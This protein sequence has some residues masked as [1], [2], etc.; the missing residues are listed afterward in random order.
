[1]NKLLSFYN[2]YEFPI[3]VFITTISA[4]HVFLYFIFPTLDGPQHLHNSNVILGLLANNPL[5]ESYYKFNPVLVSN[6]SGHVLLSLFNYFLPA[7]I[8]LNLLIFTYIMGMAFSFRYLIM[9][10]SGRFSPIGYGVFPFIMNSSLMLGLFNYCLSLILL[11]IMIG[12]WLRVQKEFKISQLVVF[13]LLLLLMNFT[14]LLSF[15]FLGIFIILFLIYNEIQNIHLHGT[16][17][18]KQ[19]FVKV[20]KLSLA[21]IPALLLVVNYLFSVSSII[22]NASSEGSDKLNIFETLYYV[23]PLIIFHVENDGNANLILFYGI[24]ALILVYLAY[25]VFNRKYAGLHNF[26]NNLM[27]IMLIV[28]LIMLIVVPPR[29]IL[30]TMRIRISLMFFLFL[31]IWLSNLKLPGIVEIIA[32]ILFLFIFSEHQFRMSHYRTQLSEHAK[33]IY[34]VEQQMEDNTT[35]MPVNAGK[36]W[37]NKHILNYLGSEKTIVNLKNPQVYGPFP[38]VW[39]LE[40]MPH[41]LYG[42]HERDEIPISFISGP[43]QSKRQEIDYVVIHYPD[44]MDM[45]RGGEEFASFFSILDS[46]FVR[47]FESAT[48]KVAL[49]QRIEK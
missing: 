37:I 16:P 3:F 41:T 30:Y 44:I 48:N 11:F 23:R 36:Q 21:S 31:I 13:G 6:L 28:T 10:V 25:R 7:N 5:I 45:E 46:E 18:Y 38:L 27:L 19:L 35:Y 22:N 32:G 2:K 26:N 17:R 43:P 24:I 1:M 20:I 4:L 47:V 29:Y 12:Y 9:S 42:G 34:S 40:K 8:A 14:H 49:F 39:N 33:E 15:V